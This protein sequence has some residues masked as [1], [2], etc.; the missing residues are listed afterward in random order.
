MNGPKSQP[1]HQ[2]PKLQTNSTAI[3]GS[4]PV[5]CS[6]SSECVLTRD[7]KGRLGIQS[8]P[9]VFLC[10]RGSIEDLIA[11]HNELIRERDEARQATRQWIEALDRY[12]DGASLMHPRLTMAITTARKTLPENERG[13]ATA[14]QDSD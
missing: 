9:E 3:A 4:S 7:L 10:T 8:A 12:G 5:P 14:P 6:L 2:M 13:L 1:T 11:R